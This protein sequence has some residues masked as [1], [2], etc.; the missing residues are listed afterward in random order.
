MKT[1]LFTLVLIIQALPARILAQTNMEM[2]DMFDELNDQ[3]SG[4][5]NVIT[6]I[7]YS[8]AGLCFLV[9][10]VDLITR[11]LR[12]REVSKEIGLYFAA[13]G[14]FLVGGFLCQKF[15]NN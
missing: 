14:L 4:S 2:S 7:C 5:L 1:K 13:M 6:I 15:F 11:V 10:L 12:G 3:I 8:I 9:G